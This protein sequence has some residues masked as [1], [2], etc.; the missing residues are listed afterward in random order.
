MVDTS[1]EEKGGMEPGI[2]AKGYCRI[3]K[4]EEA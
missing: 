2:V 4:C 1:G 3:C